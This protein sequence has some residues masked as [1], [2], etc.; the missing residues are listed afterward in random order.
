VLGVIT[1]TDV[2]RTSSGVSG[3]YEVYADIHE[4]NDQ[5]LEFFMLRSPAHYINTLKFN[6]KY[7]LQITALS[8]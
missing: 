3:T 1:F 4:V 6:G 7:R 5:C 8:I 2:F